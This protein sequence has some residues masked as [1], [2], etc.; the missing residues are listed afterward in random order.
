[1]L[2]PSRLNPKLSAYMQVHGNNNFNKNPLAPVGCK[3]IIHNRTNE[4]PS[5]FNHGPR[6]F[7]VGP[8]IK[9]YRNY[10]C[11][12]SKFKALRISNTVDFFPTT[13]ADLTMTAAK[14]YH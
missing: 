9:H 4:R 13:C 1:M 5:W 8:A 10:V 6:G 12:M 2:C 7:Y 3:I 11:F 14:N